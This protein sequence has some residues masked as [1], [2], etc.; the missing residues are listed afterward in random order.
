MQEYKGN[1]DIKVEL[2][3]G[4]YDIRAISGTGKSYLAKLLKDYARGGEPVMSYS[5]D[6]KILG[7]P[8]D[9]LV[10][11]GKQKLLMLDR[12]DLYYGEFTEQIKEF[13]KTGVVLVDVKG[14]F[15]IASEL[16]YLTMT[17]SSIEVT[18]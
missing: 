7:I 1:I 5:Y 17:E 3:N 16:C 8:F 12:Y 11:P 6:D 4:V 15:P 14:P 9:T 10:K 13:A 18:E 2:P